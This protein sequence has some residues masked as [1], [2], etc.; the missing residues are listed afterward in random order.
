MWRSFDE[1]RNK[2]NSASKKGCKAGLGRITQKDMA[3]TQFGFM[4]FV[5]VKT[6]M[7]GIYNA[8]R[9]EMEALVHVWRVVGYVLGMEDRYSTELFMLYD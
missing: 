4:G 8:T 9:E 5:M 2:H 6:E 3:L 7:M 1:V